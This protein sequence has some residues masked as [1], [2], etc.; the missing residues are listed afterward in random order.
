[1]TCNLNIEKISYFIIQELQKIWKLQKT[2]EINHVLS[3]MARVNG[4][5]G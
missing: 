3:K 2:S 4:G 1:M 5:G